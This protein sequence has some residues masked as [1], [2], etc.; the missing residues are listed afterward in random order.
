MKD[1]NSYVENVKEQ[2]YS[3][4]TDEYKNNYITYEY[5]NEQVDNNLEYF[6]NCMKDGLSEYKALL[7]FGDHLSH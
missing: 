5:S 1:F 2:L 7:F 4:A 6:K 3:N